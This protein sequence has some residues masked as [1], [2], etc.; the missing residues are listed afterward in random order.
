[1]SFGKQDP[2]RAREIFIREALVEGEWDTRLPFFAHNRKLVA[3]IEE[4][5]HK[6]RRQDVLVDD[7][8]IYAFYD[9]L[10]PAGHLHGRRVR[11]LVSRRREGA[12]SRACC[13]SRATS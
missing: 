3:D 7:E 5:E 13:S 11:A 9:Q 1:M 8:L 10:V 2:S 4:L 12:A 6:S